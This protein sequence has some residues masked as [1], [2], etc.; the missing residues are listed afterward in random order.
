MAVDPFVQN[1]LGGLLGARTASFYKLDP[2]GTAPVESIADLVPAFSPRRVVLDM[3]DS[4]DVEL[5][6]EVTTNALQD[7]RSATSNVHKALDRMTLSGTLVSSVDLALIGSVGTGGIPGIGGG[8]RAD[9]L[10][11]GYLEE[12]ANAREP[13][14]VVT[15]RRSFPQAFIES[16]APSWTPDTGDNMLVTISIVEARIVSPLTG[17]LVPDVAGSATGNNDVASAGAQ[18]PTP[19]QTQAVIPPTS[20][21]LPPTVIP[22]F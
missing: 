14:M 7:F 4:E 19:V 22:F 12:L 20:F 9:L 17:A 2:T 1:P 10:R 5:S 21:G 15:P 13:V 11:L 3:V 6:F 16:I 18:A 8:L